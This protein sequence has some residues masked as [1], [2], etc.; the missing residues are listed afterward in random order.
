M[1][2]AL[3]KPTLVAAEY[4]EVTDSRP[5]FNRRVPV[6][7]LTNSESLEE[8]K[9]ASRVRLLP[10]LTVNSLLV[11]TSNVPSSAAMLATPAT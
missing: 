1:V 2:V 7:P 5:P 8:P 3:I 4:V 9:P 6:G 11:L 10:A